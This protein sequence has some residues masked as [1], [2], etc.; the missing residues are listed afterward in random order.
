MH[1]CGTYQIMLEKLVLWLVLQ[2]QPQPQYLLPHQPQTSLL[3]TTCEYEQLPGG[4]ILGTQILGSIGISNSA[5][6]VIVKGT[7]WIYVNFTTGPDGYVS[8][9]YLSGAGST[10]N[11]ALIANLLAQLAILQAAL[12]ALLAQ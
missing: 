11:Q 6:Q 5:T 9:T 3:P 7:N 2:P 1:K 8:S 4:A 10:S 12:A